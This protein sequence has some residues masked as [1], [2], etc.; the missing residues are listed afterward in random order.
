MAA[1]EQDVAP[2]QWEWEWEVEMEGGGKLSVPEATFD[3]IREHLEDLIAVRQGVG[4]LG[5]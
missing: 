5:F 4:L 2:C 3:M 1:L